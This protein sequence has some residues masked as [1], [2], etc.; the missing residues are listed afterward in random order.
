MFSL[1]SKRTSSYQKRP[2][3]GKV[4]AKFVGWKVAD[5]FGISK[6]T[7]PT[8]KRNGNKWFRR[9]KCHVVI[10]FY[11]F[12]RFRD[13]FSARSRFKVYR[14]RRC[15]QP[16]DDILYFSMTAENSTGRWSPTVSLK[17]GLVLLFLAKR[18]ICLI[19]LFSVKITLPANIFS[20]RFVRR[21]IL[22]LLG[23]VSESF[24]K[25]ITKDKKTNWLRLSPVLLLLPNLRS[26]II[27]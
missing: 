4:G 5:T 15:H 27:R 13:L 9:N 11:L 17:N 8:T 12:V 2:T 19:L 10:F 25:W 6:R 14:F 16:T 26:S 18:E 24:P 1:T 3:G 20:I 21:S 23:E 22:P 7:R